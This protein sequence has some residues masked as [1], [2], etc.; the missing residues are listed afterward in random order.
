MRKLDQARKNYLPWLTLARLEGSGLSLREMAMQSGL[1]LRQV[2]TALANP[3]YQEFRDARLQMRVSALDA[4]F[5]ED[6]VGMLNRLRELV[7]AAI[8]VL[9]RGLADPNPSVALR[10]AAEVLERDQLFSKAQQNQHTHTYV[11]PPAELERA[12][13]IARELR[14][15]LPEAP[16]QEA[17]DIKPVS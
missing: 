14:A 16:K 6:T 1:T 7:P 2:R 11:I 17:I 9:E 8:N 5:A 4:A 3:A 10:A 13:Q 12:K 15:Y